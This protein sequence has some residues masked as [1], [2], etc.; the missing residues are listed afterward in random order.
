MILLHFKPVC[1]RPMQTAIVIIL[2][3]SLYGKNKKLAVLK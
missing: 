2:M 3:D 1:L